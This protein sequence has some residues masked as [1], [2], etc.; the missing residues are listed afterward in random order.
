MLQNHLQTS[1]THKSGF[2]EELKYKNKDSEEQTQ[3]EEKR[4]REGRSYGLI[5]PFL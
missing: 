2:N 5:H 1:T 4:K 3:N